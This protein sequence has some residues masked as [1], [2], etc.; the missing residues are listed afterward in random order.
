M[1]RPPALA[2]DERLPASTPTCIRGLLVA[3][4]RAFVDG[5]VDEHASRALLAHALDAAGPLSAWMP[6]DDFGRYAHDARYTLYVAFVVRVNVLEK[7]ARALRAHQAAVLARAPNA[8]VDVDDDTNV[9]ALAHYVH[10][11]LDAHLLMALALALA[12]GP[13]TNDSA[14]MRALLDA[15]EPSHATLLHEGELPALDGVIESCSFLSESAPTESSPSATSSSTATAAGNA[16]N[17][18]DNAD[19]AAVAELQAIFNRA[20]PRRCVVRNAMS[21]IESAVLAHDSCMY[22]LEALVAASLLGI[23]RHARVRPALAERLRIYRAFFFVPP[24]PL[25]ALLRRQAALRGRALDEASLVAQLLAVPADS[26]STED[27]ITSSYAAARRAG[28]AGTNGVVDAVDL[29]RREALYA[30]ISAR[31]VVATKT[32]KKKKTKSTVVA[33]TAAKRRKKTAGDAAPTATT[34]VQHRYLHQN[35]LVNIVREFL[36]YVLNRFLPHLVQ[37]LCA[38]TDWQAWQLATLRCLDKMRAPPPT[39]TARIVVGADDAAAATSVLRVVAPSS[40]PPKA[41]YHVQTQS[42]VESFVVAATKFL[43][44]GVGKHKTATAGDDGDGDGDGEAADGSERPLDAVVTDEIEALVRQL[45]SRYPR[46]AALVPV[47]TVPVDDAEF[48]RVYVPRAHVPLGVVYAS[49]DAVREY[50]ASMRIYARLPKPAATTAL[51]RFLA[52][53]CGMYQLQLMLAFAQAQVDRASIYVFPLAEHLARAQAA[54]VRERLNIAATEPLPRHL[55]T[56]FVCRVCRKFR[57]ALIGPS[58]RATHE[59]PTTGSEH[60]CFQTGSIDELVG[61][62]LRER[63]AVPPYAELVAEA[64]AAGGTLLNYYRRNSTI[65]AATDMYPGDPT[66]FDAAPNA[67]ALAQRWLADV[68]RE[69][70]AVGTV[71]SLD[72]LHVADEPPAY[73]ADVGAA[74]TREYRARTLIDP[75][76]TYEAYERALE[77]WAAANGRRFLVGHRSSHADDECVTW[78][79]ASRKY[80]TKERKVRIGGVA[81]RRVADSITRQERESNMRSALVHRRQDVRAYY[82][83]SKCSRTRLLTVSML[84][85]GVA[86]DEARFIACCTCLGYTRVDAAH[87]HGSLLVCT[88]CIRRVEEGVA[89]SLG[90]YGSSAS[91]KCRACAAVRKPGERFFGTCAY[92]EVARAFVDVYLCERHARKKSWLFGAANYHALSTI[93]VGL[94]EKWGSLRAWNASHDYAASVFAALDDGDDGGAVAAVAL[95]RKLIGK[96]AIDDDAVDAGSDGDDNAGSDD[97]DDDDDLF[98]AAASTTTTTTTT[99]KRRLRVRSDQRVRKAPSPQRTVEPLDLDDE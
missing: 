37:Q 36:V 86:V 27:M 46:H 81:L 72:D 43:D 30:Y 56:T 20:I 58:A 7:Y 26:A 63:R 78:T 23:Y 5:A 32:V 74:P 98:T 34:T 33:A 14:L 68:E 47:T 88:R 41:L 21:S 67:T 52:S 44:S 57:G 42:F 79:C 91:D 31:V 16:G 75:L 71:F 61:R 92:D 90:A 70:R 48:E 13:P 3:S 87:W 60:V 54:V 69:T 50:E 77:R 96:D 38:R 89:T 9:D 55:L 94:R 8:R 24:P 39:T 59:L 40:V 45:V 83:Y 85:F 53:A 76:P 10:A 62:R 35:T 65:D 18:A 12:A 49:R 22:T 19:R 1:T 2:L 97:D 99:A 66:V 25:A 6:F 84:G 11:A 28:G 4:L 93:D 64:A 82:R 51:V 29:Q 15:Y 17:D 80:K 95:A 73:T